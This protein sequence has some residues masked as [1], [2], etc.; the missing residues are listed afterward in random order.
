MASLTKDADL[1]NSSCQKGERE[2]ERE[3]ERERE[4]LQ[5]NIKAKPK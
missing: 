1:R 2:G 4:H 3:R 5:N